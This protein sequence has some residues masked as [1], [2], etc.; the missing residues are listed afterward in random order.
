[1][2]I[3]R[4]IDRFEAGCHRQEFVSISF[5]H[6]VKTD[7]ASLSLSKNRSKSLSKRRDY[8]SCNHELLS[9]FPMLVPFFPFFT[10]ESTPRF[11]DLKSKRDNFDSPR[12]IWNNASFT[13]AR[14]LSC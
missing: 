14:I 8:R 3:S 12:I 6:D 13:I 11:R 7:R 9:L 1:M 10:D 2:R 5:R 4:G